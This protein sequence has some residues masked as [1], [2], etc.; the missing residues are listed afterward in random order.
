MKNRISTKIVCELGVFLMISSVFP[1][2]IGATNSQPSTAVFCECH[3]YRG[4]SLQAPV[5]NGMWIHFDN[6]VNSNAIGSTISTWEGAIRITPDELGGYNGWKL[7]TVKWFHYVTTNPQHSGMIKIYGEGTPTSPG[8]LITTEPYTVTG[9]GWKEIPLSHFVRLNASHDI[10]VSIQINQVPGEYP[11]GV[12]NQFAVDGK[13]DWIYDGTHWIEL[14]TIQGG[15]PFFLDYNWNIWAGIEEPSLPPETPQQPAGFSEGLVGQEYTFSTNSTDPEGEPL[16]YFWDWGDGTTSDWQG[17]VASGATAFATHNWTATGNYSITVKAKDP[18]REESNWSE[19][20]TIRIMTLEK[21]VL[22]IG[23]ITGGL[24]R[25]KVRI[26]NNGTAPGVGIA[27]KITISNGSLLCGRKT[28]G[29][30]VDLEPGAMRIISSNIIL[31]YGPITI[32]VTAEIADSTATAQQDAFVY[33]FF[34]R[35]TGMTM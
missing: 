35:G 33:L 18:H 2:L 4:S 8:A 6:G 11:L 14:Q 31:G 28:S 23:N 13:G 25:V 1:T 32:N 26:F 10:W 7:C 16:Y 34:I 22:E 21:P 17:P 20:K 15:G 19:P 12:D 24:F 9:M 5:F 30:I 3:D 29:R 27:W